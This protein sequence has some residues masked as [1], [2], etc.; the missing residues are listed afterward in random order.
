MGVVMAPGST[1]ARSGYRP[2]IDGLRAVAIVAVIC[3]HFNNRV[4][5][6]GFLGVDIFF[7]ISGYVISASLA[8]RRHEGFAAFL[9]SFY[10]RRL[11][12]LWPALILVIAVVSILICLVNPSPGL[13]LQTGLA[14]LIGVANLYLYKL[15]TDYF[16]GSTELNVFTHLWSLGVEEQFYFL[17]PFLFWFSG[18][19]RRGSRPGLVFGGIVGSLSLLSLLAYLWLRSHDPEAAFFMLPARFWELGLGCLS[20]LFYRR[21]KPGAPARLAS[22]LCMALILAAFLVPP[23]LATVSTLTVVFATAILISLLTCNKPLQRLLS[24]PYLVFIGLISYSLYLWHW[25]IISLSRWTIGIHWWSVPI[26]LFLIFIISIA[27]Y[28]YLETRLRSA[29]WS[30]SPSITFLYGALA[31]AGCAGLIT[32]L[33]LPLQGRL[34]VGGQNQIAVDYQ[35]SSASRTEI[36][37]CNLF[38]TPASA[39]DLSLSCGFKAP[40]GKPMIYLLGDSHI[41]QFRSAIAGFAKTNG[42]GFHGVWGNACPYPALPSYAFPGN[43][44]KQKCILSQRALE[45]ALLAKIKP[46]D[47]IFIGDYLT[48]YFTPVA[49]GKDLERAKR[50]YRQRL[51]SAADALVERGAV[52]VLYL[53]APRFPGLEG[54]SEGYC[55]PQWFKPALSANCRVDAQ[56]FVTQREKDF[57]WIRAWSDGGRR[58]VWDGVDPTTCDRQQCYAAHYKDE[59]HFLDYYSTYIFQKFLAAHPRFP[60]S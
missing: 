22:W 26:Q 42:F 40:D 30:S 47:V 38:D 29:K 60:G 35:R 15:K 28:R 44:A 4:L 5:P 27:S 36:E 50:D 12:R 57:G 33:A 7:V 2:E 17:Y 1:A 20:F 39:S 32:A 54:M 59:A 19:G 51:Q 53:N 6:G 10:Q 23:S 55:Y 21:S 25:P 18:L 46:G 37:I 24:L 11:K 34:F 41:H 16:A 52:V 48:S 31:S 9:S 8:S 56:S 14:G 58:L 13:S 45:D 3:N 49:G 43:E